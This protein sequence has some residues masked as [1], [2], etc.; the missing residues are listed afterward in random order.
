[1]ASLLDSPPFEAQGF[2]DERS[3]HDPREREEI[4]GASASGKNAGCVCRLGH[5]IDRNLEL[6]NEVWELKGQSQLNAWGV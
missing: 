5:Q 4:P 2:E 6:Q 1:M 3:E